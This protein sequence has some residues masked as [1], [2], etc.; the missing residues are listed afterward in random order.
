MN[1]YSALKDLLEIF[2]NEI[3]TNSKLAIALICFI[4]INLVVTLLNIFSQNRLKNKEKQ[5]YSFNLKEKRRIEILEELYTKMEDLSN[6]DGKER[7]DEFLQQIKEMEA[8]TNKNR[9]YLPKQIQKITNEYSDYLKNVLTDFRKKNY[10]FEMNI[11][12]KY[13]KLFA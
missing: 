12:N 9:L 8:F 3:T 1:D 13:C 4:G 5:I 10:E 2:S 6:F 11:F 7:S